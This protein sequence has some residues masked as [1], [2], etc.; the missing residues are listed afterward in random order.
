M[1]DSR[2][3]AGNTW[4][5]PRVSCNDRK[6]LLLKMAIHEKDTVVKLKKLPVAKAGIIWITK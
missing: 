2:A 4:D 5:E 6:Q 1:T 3:G